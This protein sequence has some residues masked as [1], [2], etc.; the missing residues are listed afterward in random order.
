MSLP[1][2]RFK[3]C[4]LYNDKIN[5]SQLPKLDSYYSMDGY[6]IKSIQMLGNTNYCEIDIDTTFVTRHSHFMLSP[7]FMIYVPSTSLVVYGKYLLYQADD[8]DKIYVHN[9]ERYEYSQ[10][11]RIIRHIARHTHWILNEEN[12]R[13]IIFEYVYGSYLNGACKL[14]EGI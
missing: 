1:L 4:T 14:R 11:Y 2:E 13:E 10:Y 5:I 8:S 9:M 6:R 3:R 12:I 7:L